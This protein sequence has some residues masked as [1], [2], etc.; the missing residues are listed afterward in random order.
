MRARHAFPIIFLSAVAVAQS[1]SIYAP[2][3]DQPAKNSV[4]ARDTILTQD[5]IRDLIRKAAD[6]DMQNDKKQRDYLYT[7]RDEQHNLDGKGQVKSTESKTYEV[8]EI[9][10]EQTQKLVAKDDKPL[11]EKDTQKEDEKIQKLIDK[12]K[13][14]SG[15]DHEKRLAKEAKEQEEDRRFVLEAA[16]A[17][18]FKFIGHEVIEG[19]DNYVIDANPKPGYE[20]K[21]KEARI[22]TKFRGRL[23]IDVESEQMKKVDAECIDTVSW[24]LFIA[25]IHKGS[26]VVVVQTRVNDEV[27]LPQHITVKLD[28][29]VALMKEYNIDFDVAYRDYKKFRTETKII[30]GG[31]VVE[32]R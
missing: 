31:E 23:W 8:M 19:R 3:K 5:Q 13:D 14:E 4:S 28:A 9:Y 2:P 26:R 27:W 25:R 22:L 15:E 6:N 24:G 10:G 20:P 7:E 30:P 17:Y 11:S 18:D 12:R 1:D 32:Q 16:D 21:I 29:R